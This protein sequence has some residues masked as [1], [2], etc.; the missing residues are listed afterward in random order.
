[1]DILEGKVNLIDK[2]VMWTNKR[3][4]TSNKWFDMEQ[5]S[6]RERPRDSGKGDD[7]SGLILR[8]SIEP[9][10]IASKDFD[11][12]NYVAMQKKDYG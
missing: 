2:K 4:V 3:G 1:M 10:A 9:G 12:N 5:A 7:V 11:I 6:A 8:E